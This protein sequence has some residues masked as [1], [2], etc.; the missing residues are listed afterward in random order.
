MGN[1]KFDLLTFG[2]GDLSCEIEDITAREFSPPT[3]WSLP[4]WVAVHKKA[5]VKFNL[6]F[7]TTMFSPLQRKIS[8]PPDSHDR[9]YSEKFKPVKTTFAAGTHHNKNQNVTETIKWA[10]QLQKSRQTFCDDRT[11]SRPIT[12]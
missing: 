8:D 4:M 5:S 7:E 11:A 9:V 12:R 1:Q 10:L 2:S 3:T 6:S